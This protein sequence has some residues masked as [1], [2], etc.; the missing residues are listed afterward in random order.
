MN[1]QELHNM[2][3][4]AALYMRETQLISNIIALEAQV[5]DLQR[6]LAQA[7]EKHSPLRAVPDQP[8]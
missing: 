5:E 7:G 8:A 4:Q 3:L 6:Q 2:R 1:P